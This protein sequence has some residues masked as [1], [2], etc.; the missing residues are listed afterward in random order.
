MTNKE[1]FKDWLKFINVEL[2]GL[3]LKIAE[4]AWFAAIAYMQEQGKLAEQRWQNE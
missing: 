4:A 1:A 3:D 2:T